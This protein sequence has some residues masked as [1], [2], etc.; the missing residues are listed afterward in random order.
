MESN[1]EL[2][3]F[4]RMFL[5]YAEKSLFGKL[6]RLERKEAILKQRELLILNAPLNDMDENPD[7]WGDDIADLRAINDNLIALKLDIEHAFNDLFEIERNIV[8]LVVLADYSQQEV[9]EYLKVNQ[10]NVSRI[11]KR[12]LE[13]LKM[14][15]MD[16]EQYLSR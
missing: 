15:L 3:E 2:E 14:K 7:E 4:E 9:A 13:K 5:A 1:L 12:A 11:K 16:D 6:A 8:I 10:S